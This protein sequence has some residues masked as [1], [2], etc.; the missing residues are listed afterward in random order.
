MSEVKKSVT[1]AA[2]EKILATWAKEKLFEQTLKN[3]QSAPYF[4]FYDGPP[5]ASGEPHYGHLEQ[6]AVKDSIAR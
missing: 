4:S 2:E 6:T 3:R 5:F 1:A